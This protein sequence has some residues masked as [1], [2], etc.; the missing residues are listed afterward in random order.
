MHVP[1]HLKFY[2]ILKIYMNRT[3]CHLLMAHIYKRKYEKLHNVY[4]VPKKIH[5]ETIKISF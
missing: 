3:T 1:I 2:G 4:I 5:A